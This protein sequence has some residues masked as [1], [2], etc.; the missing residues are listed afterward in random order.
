MSN[1]LLAHTNRTDAGTLSNGTWN[2]SL[3]LNNLKDG[4][5]DKVARSANATAASTRFAL[6]MGANFPVWAIALAATNISAN[7][8]TW[9]VKGGTAAPDSVNVFATGQVFN[10]TAIACRQLTFAWDTPADWGLQ[11]NLIYALAAPQTVRYITV[12]IV[13]TANAAGF[14]QIG[15]LFVGTGFQPAVNPRKGWKSGREDLST[16]TTADSGKK[17]FTKRLPRPRWEDLELFRL[18]AGEGDQVHEM[19]ALL[20]ITDEVLYVPDPAD[21]AKSQRYGFLGTMRELSVLDAPYS[22]GGR[23]KAYRIDQK[24]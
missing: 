21:L 8:S 9:Q 14:V 2:G 10:S 22:D 18:T 17:F 24:L 3:P 1:I 23:S 4:N 7:G 5:I 20:G 11:Y 16:F 19:D 13:D 6:D 12:D 15:R